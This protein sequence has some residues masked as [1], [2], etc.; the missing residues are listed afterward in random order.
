MARIFVAVILVLQHHIFKRNPPRVADTGIFGASA[1]QFI[2]AIFT[3]QGYQFV[4]HLFNH[5]VQRYRQIDVNLFACARHHRHDTR[6]RQRDTA[7]RKTKAVAVHNDLHRVADIVEVI[8][9][10]PHA[11]EDNVGQ[12]AAIGGVMADIVV[13]IFIRRC[14]GHIALWPFAQRITCQH[15]LTDDFAGRQIAH[16][17]HCAGMTEPAIQ[18]AANLA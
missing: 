9:R 4:T 18:R 12:H 17:P 8:K 3:V 10:L 2:N 14:K 15:D 16:Q 1:E 11:H 5:C 13:V 6:R 7:T